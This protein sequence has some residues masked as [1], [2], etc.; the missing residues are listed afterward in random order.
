MEV[1]DN[2]ITIVQNNIDKTIGQ[3]YPGD[4]AKTKAEQESDDKKHRSYTHK[5]GGIYGIES[6]KQLNAGGDGNDG[7]SGGEVRPSVG[8]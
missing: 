6:I 1:P 5:T 2:K 7:G 3:N 8:V 4:T